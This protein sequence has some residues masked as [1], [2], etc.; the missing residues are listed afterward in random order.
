MY[1][2]H[3][4]EAKYKTRRERNMKKGMLLGLLMA[5]M[6]GCSGIKTGVKFGA[7]MIT[8]SAVHQGGHYIGAKASGVEIEWVD[9]FESIPGFQPNEH[10]TSDKPE[11]LAYGGSLLLTAIVAELILWKGLDFGDEGG[12]KF[13]TDFWLGYLAMASWDE[14]SYGLGRSGLF[15]GKGQN[16]LG[17]DKF[18]GHHR[19]A[20]AASAVHGASILYRLR[21]H[22]RVI[23]WYRK[24]KILVGFPY[25]GITYIF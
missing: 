18:G 6:F 8:Q 20:G 12:D 13:M 10:M 17:R 23:S 9:S 11:P 2:I 5:A 14:M 21:K 3:H 7:G 25:I 24:V 15:D 1:E 19:A 22:K 16:D 4:G